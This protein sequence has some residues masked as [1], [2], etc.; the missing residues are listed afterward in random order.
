MDKL[1]LKRGTL[2]LND[3]QTN[4]P[5][6]YEKEKNNLL[7]IFGN[8]IF[9]IDH[10]GSTSIKGIKSK[11]IIDILI[12]TN[13]LD[14]F[15]NFTKSNI[16]GDIYTTKK[17]TNPGE[18][19]LIRKE[20]NGK[21]KA[22]VHVYETGDKNAISN[23]LFRDYL[24]SHEEEKKN[25]EKLKIELYEKYKDNRKEYTLGK[26]KFIKEIIKKATKG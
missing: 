21:V 8:K 7:D 4:Y 18:G 15:I 2:E 12:Q 23:I 6:I 5:E 17:E 16:E 10:I 3:Y 19:F 1:G 11:P 22:F 26:D 14:D 20:E 13:D 24:N 9:S 25:Y